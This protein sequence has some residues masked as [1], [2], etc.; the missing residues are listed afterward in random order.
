M[1]WRQVLIYPDRVDVK[2]VPVALPNVLA[3]SEAVAPDNNP[4][5]L[6]RDRDLNF[7]IPRK[8]FP[9]GA[10]KTLASGG[11]IATSARCG[12]LKEL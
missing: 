3:E 1:M 10:E 8:G 2:S 6:G 5:L 12:F 11:R 9:L 4:Y 7:S